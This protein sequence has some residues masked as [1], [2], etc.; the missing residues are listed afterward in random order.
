MFFA[1]QEVCNQEKSREIVSKVEKLIS[2]TQDSNR[3][4]GSLRR[5][6]FDAGDSPHIAVSSLATDIMT[7]YHLVLRPLDVTACMS[8]R[9]RRAVE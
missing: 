5:T 4:R 2:Y 7:T 8:L 9:L 1:G 3:C 6:L